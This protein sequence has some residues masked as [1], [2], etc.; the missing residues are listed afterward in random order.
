MCSS[1]WLIMLACALCA[2]GGSAGAAGTRVPDAAV[3][4]GGSVAPSSVE[5]ELQVLTYNVAGLPEGISGS[6]PERNT[7]QISP[8]LNPYDLVFV[9]EDFWYHASLVAALELPYRSEPYRTPAVLEDIGDGLSLFSRFQFTGYQRTP[10]GGCHG[11]F[12]CASDCLATKGFSFAR[13]TLAAGVEI[14]VYNLHMEAGGCAEDITLRAS[15]AALLARTILERSP[16][17]AVIVAGDFNLHEEDPV[18]VAVLDQLLANAT[19]A[20]ACRV[21]AC[22][23]P[24]IDRVLYRSGGG[25]TLTATSWSIPEHFVDAE[26][27][28]RLSDHQPVAVTLTY[29]A[30]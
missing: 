30:N 21:L 29:A 16:D 6:H 14:D 7:P 1:A 11:Q 15:G 20:D 19:L 28:E 8:L 27:G 22:T 25:V 10:W 3:S 12:D 24:K 13:V 17:R 9:Q 4:D 26:S 5:G 2:C 18:D 23:R